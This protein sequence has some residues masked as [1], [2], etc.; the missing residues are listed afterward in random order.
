M[1]QT[2]NKFK[3]AHLEEVSPQANQKYA[4]STLS[5]NEHTIMAVLAV[6]APFFGA[7][8]MFV[9]GSLDTVNAYLIFFG[10]IEP[11]GNVD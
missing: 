10:Q 11:E 6:I 2:G 9:L 1:H 4:I 3:F 5:T 7:T 8:L